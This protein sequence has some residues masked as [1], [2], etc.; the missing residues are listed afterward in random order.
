MA[1][2]S[3]T[4][5]SSNPFKELYQEY[6]SLRGI[7]GYYE[8]HNGAVTLTSSK[9]GDLSLSIFACTNLKNPKEAAK[10]KKAIDENRVIFLSEKSSSKNGT[11]GYS[12]HLCISPAQ[13]SDFTPLAGVK[14]VAVSVTKFIVN[15]VFTDGIRMKKITKETMDQIYDRNMKLLMPVLLAP[16]KKVAEEKK[17]AGVASSSSAAKYLQD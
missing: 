2:T 16:I 1:S 17:A 10:L 6:E 11:I 4:Y 5:T 8:K 14:K 7:I 13:E 9:S 12:F 15:I 3:S